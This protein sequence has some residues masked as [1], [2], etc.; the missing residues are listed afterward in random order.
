MKTKIFKYLGAGIGAVVVGMVLMFGASKVVYPAISQLVGLAVAE[1]ATKWNNVR[2]AS[3]GDNL[4]S[5]I[6]AMSLYMW[7]GTNFDRLRGSIAN[8]ILV[9]VTRVTGSVTVIGTATDNTTNSTAKLPT[10]PCRANAAAPSWTEGFM[11]PCSVDLAGGLRTSGGGS[12]SP[13]EGATLLNSQTVSVANTALTVTLTGAASQRVHLYRISR[14]TC[15]PAG[16]ATIQINDGA[17]PIWGS[18]AG[19]PTFPLS[20]EETWPVGLTGTTAANLAVVI[21]SCGTGNQ[22]VIEVQADR[23]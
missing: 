16:I 2:D 12:S 11:V 19:V 1:S 6:L 18:N 17:T 8:G 20:M 4:T 14:V 13:V 7:D 15:T 10:I 9:D 3:V 21:G 23:F 22:S 5:G